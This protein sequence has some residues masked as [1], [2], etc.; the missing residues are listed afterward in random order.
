M[1]LRDFVREGRRV[2][3][4]H[5]VIM[6]DEVCRT[7]GTDFDDTQLAKL[8]KWAADQGTAMLVTTNVCPLDKV[9]GPAGASRFRSLVV[10][11]P[12]HRQT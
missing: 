5:D 3:E 4:R 10:K 12:D 7:S 2:V 6:L 11:G 1:E 9:L 8:A